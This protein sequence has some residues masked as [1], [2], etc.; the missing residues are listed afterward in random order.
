MVEGTGAL[1]PPA[2]HRP[3]G[4]HRPGR[5]GDPLERAGDHRAARSRCRWSA[6]RGP[7]DASYRMARAPLDWIDRELADLEAKGLRRALEPL[8]VAA[9]AG[10]R[11]AA[12]GGSSTSAPTTTSA[13]P[14]TSGCRQAAARAALEE[15]A[16]AGA[17]RLV[18]GDL[19]IHGELEAALAG[20]PRRAGGA[21]LQLRLPR[22][23]RRP[24]GAGGARRRRL[25]RRPQPR[26]H[27]RRRAPLPRRPP[28][29]PPPR[30]WTSSTGC[31]PA[32]RPAGS[33]WSPT[34]SSPWTATPP[35]SRALA[36]LCDRHGAMLYV[37]EAH[38]VGVLGPTGAGLAEAE[39]VKGRVDV[40]MGTL[41]KALGAF[42]AYV[43]GE[44]RLRE[45][46]RRGPAPSSSPPRCRRPPAARPWRRWRSSAASRP[47]GPGSTPSWPA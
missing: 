46:L 33:W 24:G 12:A 43:A 45:L 30:R 31:W 10:G 39:G 21:P 38:A 22:Q 36:D 25:L 41:G 32:P 6:S 37:D 27:R 40:E 9:G 17:S 23:R 29:L 26:L 5:P 42:G 8:A 28:A 44:A 16:G 13:W 11:G 4:L 14:A 15:G 1:A 34:R 47:G 20:L 2:R 7:V 19:P 3:L 35:R 18:A